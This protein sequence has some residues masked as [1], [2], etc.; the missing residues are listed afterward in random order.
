MFG[1]SPPIAYICVVV[2]GYLGFREL[3]EIQGEI[4][5][6]RWVEY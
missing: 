1:G 3:L 4:A 6:S 5:G 2:P